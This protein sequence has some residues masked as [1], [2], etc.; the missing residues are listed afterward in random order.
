MK[1]VKFDQLDSSIHA[2]C[3]NQGLSYDRM[4][5][6]FTTTCAVNAYHNWSCE[7]EPRWW[8]GVLDTTLCDKVGQWL[9]TGLWFSPSTPFSSN[10]KTDHHDITEILSKSS[11]NL[12]KLTKPTFKSRL[13]WNLKCNSAARLLTTKGLVVK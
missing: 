3:K 7:F 1:N 2:C 6:G 12:H 13:I 4:V 11:I 10:N 9:A 5:V 8:W